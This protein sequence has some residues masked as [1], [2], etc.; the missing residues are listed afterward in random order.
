MLYTEYLTPWERLDAI[1]MGAASALAERGITPSE[2]DRM[3]K[4]ANTTVNIKFPAPSMKAL[5][6]TAVI[7]GVPLG[8]MYYVINRSINKSDRK[9]RRLQREL[10]YYNDVV[11]EFKNNYEAPPGEE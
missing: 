11:S 9:T 10:D 1:R 5:M 7:A 8:L 2:L 6:N 4:R 3:T